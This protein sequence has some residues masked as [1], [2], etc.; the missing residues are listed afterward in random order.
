MKTTKFLLVSTAVFLLALCTNAQNL[1]TTIRVQA[2]DMGNA[3]I[4][5]DFNSF[6][7]YMHPDVIAFAG[8]KEQLKTKMDSA[9]AMMKQFNVTFKRYW[10]GSPGEIIKYK[11][12][13]QAVLPEGTTL[14]T[15]L[16]E[17]TAETSVIAIS[18]DKGK[19]WWF[20]DTSVYNL[21]KLRNVMPDLSPKLVIPPRK[22]PKLVPIQN[23]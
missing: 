23:N 12:S 3:V 1:S 22:K 13:L 2:M 18:N 16:G 15:P 11:K 10:I 5:N 17:M 6:V 20:I 4:K 9:Y 8:G 19:N 7:K 21:E 14:I